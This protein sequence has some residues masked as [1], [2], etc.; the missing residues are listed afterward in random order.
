M[1]IVAGVDFGTLS[2]RVSLFDSAK[3]KLG[4]GVGE[5]PLLRKKEDPDHA[6]QSH[7]D[8]MRALASAMRAALADAGI[9]GSAVEAIALDTTCGATIAPG[10]RPLKSLPRRTPAG[11]PPSTGA[12]ASTLPS[13]ASPNCCTGCATTPQSAPISPPRW[14]IATWWPPCCAVSTTWPPF[15]AA[16]APWAISGCGTPRWAASRRKNS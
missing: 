16:S 8:H 5:Y 11:S 4:A 1:S 6:T 3:G 14:N 13:G 12:A 10:R 9:E 2:V 15:R 7:Q